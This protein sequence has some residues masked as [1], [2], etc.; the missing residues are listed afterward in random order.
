ML[1]KTTI[2]NLHTHN[3]L[4]VLLAFVFYYRFRIFYMFVFIVQVAYT[5]FY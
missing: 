3:V 4:A 2:D 5:N 1:Y